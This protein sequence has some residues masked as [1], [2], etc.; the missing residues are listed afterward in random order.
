[1]PPEDNPR[2]DVPPEVPY[3]EPFTVHPDN[4]FAFPVVLG[5]AHRARAAGCPPEYVRHYMELA[6]LIRAWQR[7]NPGKVKKLPTE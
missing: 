4:P 5:Y 6:E 2:D 7:E 3:P 1:M